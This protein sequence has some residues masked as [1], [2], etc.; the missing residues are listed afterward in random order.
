MNDAK[1]LDNLVG[2]ACAKQRKPVTTSD[3]I[4]EMLRRS[5]ETRLSRKSST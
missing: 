4:R 1:L 2:D 3:V 5:A